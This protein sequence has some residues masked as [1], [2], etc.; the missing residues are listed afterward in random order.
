MSVVPQLSGFIREEGRGVG[1][2]GKRGEMET[3]KN[4]F[5]YRING[6]K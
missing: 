4:K 5:S 3:F 1:G 6:K 2:G